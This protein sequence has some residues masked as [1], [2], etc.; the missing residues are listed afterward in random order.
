MGVLLGRGLS[1]DSEVLFVASMLHD[2]GLTDAFKEESDPR[3]VPDYAGQEAPCFAVRGGRVAQSL[4]AIHGWPFPRQ[5]ALAEAISMHLNVR[6][7]RSQGVE[8][9]LLNAASALDVIRLKSHELPYELIRS[10]EARWPRGA[11]FCN[12]LWA[13]WVDDS[14][15]HPECR[16]AFL[17]RWGS[18]KRRINRTCLASYF[19][20][21]KWVPP[22][23]GGCSGLL[24][25]YRAC[26]A[27]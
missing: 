23:G 7:A 21:K 13:A 14:E 24:V 4:A 3:L 25:G 22:A 6:V 5:Y 19:D 15:A 18:F 17:N 10:I 12:D 16:A 11:T 8:A 2:V 9:H 1:F 20:L 27:A 26:G